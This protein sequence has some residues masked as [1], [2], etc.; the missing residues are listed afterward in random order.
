MLGAVVVVSLVTTGTLRAQEPRPH[1]LGAEN[2]VAAIGSD[3]DARAVLSVVFAHV[4]Q[5]SNQGRREFLLRSQIRPEWLP[6][7][8]HVDVALMTEADA[9]TLLSACGTYWTVTHVERSDTVVSLR[10]A[11]RC[12]GMTRD[13]IVSLNGQQWRLGP[14]G[15]G[16]N[17]GG[18]VPGIGCG[19]AQ[20][21]TG[22][23]C[24]AQTH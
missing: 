13:Y 3:A 17:G 2:I 14:P 12:G 1:V 18:W 21:P 7:V 15:T 10:L 23:P 8:D 5:P 11:S 4:F 6:H 22:C 9:E 19:F 24:S 16:A 20:R